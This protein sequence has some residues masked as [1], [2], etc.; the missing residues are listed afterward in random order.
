MSPSTRRRFLK[1]S[2][3]SAVSAAAATAPGILRSAGEAEKIPLAIIGPGGM[4]MNHVRTLCQ[5]K[6]VAFHWVVDA[7]RQR[8]EAAAKH[9]QD[10]TGQTPK[11]SQDMRPAIEDAAVR[12][13]FMA[14]PDHWHAPGAIYAADAGKHVYV[15]KPCSHNL[16]EGRL[17]I[18]AAARNHVRMQVG[19]QSR[20]TAHVRTAIEKIRGGV[21]GEVLIAKAWNSQLRKNHGHQPFTEP[22][23]SLDYEMWLGPAPKVPFR[24]TYHPAHWRWFHHFGTGDIGNDGVHDIDIA[25][26]GLGVTSH[27]NRVTA[28]GSK[29]FFDDDQQWPDSIY[30]GFEYD[31]E[32]GKRQLFYEQRDWS[33]YVQ[34]GHENGCAWYG[35]EG[36]VVG[37]KARGWRIF[38]PKNKLIEEIPANGVDLAA[39]HENFLAAVRENL[40]AGPGRDLHASIEI[41]HLSSSLCH[42]AN[43]AARTGRNLRFDP[44]TETIAGDEEA[45]ALLRREYREHWATPRGV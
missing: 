24:S 35:T 17:M 44:E 37:G 42:L 18:D 5:R 15:E 23:A 34:E 40:A 13:C 20:G 41:H 45:A 31:T 25:R 32:G 33:P 39:H 8:A 19:T 29:L 1:S 6:D 9:I 27:P 10:T 36:M 4:G 14:T 30:A 43:I 12:A 16:R 22:P 38:G 7:D 26:W 21:I 28:L 2:T 3:L 11:I